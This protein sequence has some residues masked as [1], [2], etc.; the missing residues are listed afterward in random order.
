MPLQDFNPN[1]PMPDFNTMQALAQQLG[2]PLP[3]AV[4]G[5]GPLQN[6]PGFPGMNMNMNMNNSQDQHQGTNTSQLSGG[7]ENPGRL[8][9]MNGQDNNNNSND[10]MD[11]NNDG[12]QSNWNND[13]GH[14]GGRQGG[15]KQR[16]G[17][18]AW[19]DSGGEP[20]KFVLPCKYWPGK[21]RKGANCTY[22]HEGAEQ[23]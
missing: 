2:F 7:F 13:G 23:G 11:W 5:N 1:M 21:C 8:A 10:A 3:G 9:L 19:K 22:V 12:G 20:P 6:L 18:R 14:G 4:F 15:N 17:G 16:G